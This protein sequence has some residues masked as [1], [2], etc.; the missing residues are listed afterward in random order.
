MDITTTP[1]DPAH[2]ELS[3]PVNAATTT[4]ATSEAS[5]YMAPTSSATSSASTLASQPAID[6]GP[7]PSNAIRKPVVNT[8]AKDALELNEAELTPLTKK[9]TKAE[10]KGV[11]DLGAL[12]PGIFADAYDKDTE[13]S[14]KIVRMWGVDIDPQHPAK[15]ARVSV[16]LVKFLRAQYVTIIGYFKSNL[17]L[18]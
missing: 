13:A 1:G 6:S 18:M 14:N 11:R 9:F 12:L 10:W 7:I 17:C 15:D 2:A 16:I 8:H 3:S 5:L 4:S